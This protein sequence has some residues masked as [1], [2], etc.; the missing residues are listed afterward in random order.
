MGNNSSHPAFVASH[1]TTERERERESKLNLYLKGGSNSIDVFWDEVPN[2]TVYTL[3]WTPSSNS[4]NRTDNSKY[5]IQ[6]LSPCTNYTVTLVAISENSTVLASET[7]CKT[8]SKENSN[9]VKNMA[10]NS[11]EGNITILLASWTP[12]E[13]PGNCTVYYRITW[14]AIGFVNTTQTDEKPEISNYTI[15]GLKGCTQYNV[16]VVTRTDTS[17]S[18]PRHS[19]NNTN[20]REPGKPSLK[21]T[22]AD[23][24]SIT[25]KW[26]K[27]ESICAITLY[28]LIYDDKIQ[29]FSSGKRYYTATRLSQHSKYTFKLKANN[30]AGFGEAAILDTMTTGVDPVAVGV[31]VGVSVGVVLLAVGIAGYIY[32]DK[33]K[34]RCM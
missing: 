31:G 3:S 19:S 7:K 25:M 24:H 22:S 9:A 13:R 6:S 10:V 33:I 32:R 2:T 11:V 1:S 14:S 4:V 30:D 28:Q 27:P 20:G 21:Q 8:L 16:S 15:T 5:K 29:N 12:P 26:T 23:K 18:N 17:Y 34:N